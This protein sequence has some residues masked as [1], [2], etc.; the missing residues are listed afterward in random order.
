[1]VWGIN[2][3]SFIADLKRQ[4]K[5]TVRSHWF[6]IAQLKNCRSSALAHWKDDHRRSSR[7][8]EPL[9]EVVNLS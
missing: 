9:S 6:A 2:N 4:A 8:P 1:M 7:I 3:G 5:T